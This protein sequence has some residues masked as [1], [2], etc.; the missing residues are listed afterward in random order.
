MVLS[1][2]EKSQ[3]NIVCES[4]LSLTHVIKMRL[5]FYPLDLLLHTTP[6]D[7]LEILHTTQ[8][9]LHIRPQSFFSLLQAY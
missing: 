8:S 4:H 7:P 1:T 9:V 6:H 5:T 2:N 3:K